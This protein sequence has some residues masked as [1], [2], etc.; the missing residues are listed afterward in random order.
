MN[1][2]RL[3]QII[4]ILVLPYTDR[5]FLEKKEDFI[6][7]HRRA[8]WDLKY[9]RSTYLDC[10]E[11]ENR[12]YDS[13]KKISDFFRIHNEY[14][15]K[16]LD[17]I[18]LLLDLFYSEE[19]LMVQ[20]QQYSKKHGMNVTDY[21]ERVYLSKL[22][23]IA[24]SLLTF[25]DGKIA[26]R[27]WF[28][29]KNDIF[30][31][32]SVFDKIE[33]WNQLGRLMT[34]DIIIAAFFVLCDLRDEYYLTN[35][36]GSIMLADKTLEHI[37][38]K[39]LA[40]THLHFNA[41]IDFQYLWQH[42]MNPISWENEH[43]RNSF[44]DACKEDFSG[45]PMMVYR[46]IWAEYLETG[47]KG[48]FQSYIQIEYKEIS[49]LINHVFDRI[50]SG[51]L[52]EQ[53]IEVERRW[54]EYSL[55][56]DMIIQRYT[57]KNGCRKIQRECLRD[58]DDFLLKTVFSHY[59]KYH[60]SGELLLLFKSLWLFQEAG[61]E[62]EIRL[63]LQYI[64]CKNMFFGTIVRLKMV[65]G[66]S[67]FR[68][69][70]SNMTG[71]L[72]LIENTDERFYVIFKSIS[73]NV[74]LKKLEVRI[75]PPVKFQQYGMRFLDNQ[76][77]HD[78]IRKEYLCQIRDVLKAFKNCML[79]SGGLLPGKY[80]V[81][82]YVENL[83]NLYFESRITIPTVGIVFHFLKRD[84]VD[85]KVGESCWI[86]NEDLDAPAYKNIIALRQ[87]MIVSAKVLEELR[88]SIPLLSEY[89][90]GLDAASEENIAEPWIFAPVFKA[91]RQKKLTKPLL[92][93]TTDEIRRNNNIGFT[94]HV[95]EEFRHILSGLRHV[96]E[97][98]NEFQYKAGDRLGHALSLGTNIDYWMSR[99]EAVVMPIQEY[100]EDLLWL[101]GK[102]VYSNWDVFFDIDVLEGQIMNYVK[103]VLGDV[104]GLTL[105]IVYDAYKLKFQ[106][107]YKEIFKKA[108]GMLTDNPDEFVSSVSSEEH[109]CKFYSR[110]S[111][112][113]L[114]WTSQKVF[115]T[116]FCPVYYYRYNRPIL[117]HV[118]KNKTE[119]LKAVQKAVIKEVEQKGIYI[120]TNPTSNLS[121]GEV[122]S[123]MD[124]GIVNL[125]ASGLYRG[126]EIENEVL[127]T[128]NSDN[129][130]IFNTNCENEHA[131][132]YHSLTYKGYPKERVL[133]W[134]D[135]VR[136]MGMDSSFVKNVKKPSVQ[137]SEIDS[138]LD[139]LER[140]LCL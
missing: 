68:K 35:Q 85:N 25:R 114:I 64:R 32:P 125:N 42:R 139:N 20:M 117:V 76:T 10:E 62:E 130:V 51:E 83:D 60:T 74:Y 81:E 39:G 59:Q 3:E 90:V 31:Y 137:L 102:R 63:F 126:E 101:W 17:D 57:E 55:L 113:G 115:C 73:Q 14:R 77:I 71:N 99:N 122:N 7:T 27:T 100:L 12:Y 92:C 16:N 15:V 72:L 65:E 8:L 29:P 109:F 105:P 112:Y 104:C 82:E 5:E 96:D 53:S 79:E 131:Y 61:N 95:G 24:E 52:I 56:L 128:V 13:E 11:A 22:F 1:K 121:I 19:K 45:F 103:M 33:I 9:K 138:L 135:K 48:G 2:Q 107:D 34:T 134:I 94:Y 123:L 78:E 75:K 50:A 98:I 106:S 89:V 26:I 67:N 44:F 110:K 91:I 23:E 38:K 133:K 43:K 49:G 140:E 84:Y 108:R 18:K 41:G 93:E 47:N 58:T 118:E 21:I 70:Y 30:N 37:F 46:I 54:G 28:N 111:P 136:Q 120:E 87:A 40:E 97:V 88:S 4:Q 80:R 127:T 86:E 119:L 69:L 116:F 6:K 129:P 124:T 132:I 36:S 66:L